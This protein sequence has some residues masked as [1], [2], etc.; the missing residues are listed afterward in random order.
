MILIPTHNT[1]DRF[2]DYK[3]FLSLYGLNGELNKL[4]KAGKISEVN[5]FFAWVRGDK[6]YPQK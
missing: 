5:L 6:K 2:S 3:R 1:E 4:V